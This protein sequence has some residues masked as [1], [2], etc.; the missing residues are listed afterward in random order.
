[1]RKLRLT[2]RRLTRFTQMGTGYMPSCYRENVQQDNPIKYGSS[3]EERDSQW[4]GES[5]EGGTRGDPQQVD[6]GI[7]PVGCRLECPRGQSAMRGILH[8]PAEQ[9][10]I[11]F[12]PG[13]LRSPVERLKTDF[14]SGG[15]HFPAGRRRSRARWCSLAGRRRIESATERITRSLAV[16]ASS[17]PEIAV[18]R[19]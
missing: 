15:S 3:E 9:P 1:M 11:L 12:A 5:G 8:S 2:L 17:D 13:G 4:V 18:E 10:S 7:L 16:L 14:A 6:I 19:S